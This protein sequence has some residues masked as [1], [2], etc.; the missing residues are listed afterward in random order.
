MLLQ[1]N[2]WLWIKWIRIYCTLHLYY[3]STNVTILLVYN[4]RLRR[5]KMEQRKLTDQANTVADLAKVCAVFLLFSNKNV[6][7]ASVLLIYNRKFYT[8]NRHFYPVWTKFSLFFVSFSAFYDFCNNLNSE[9]PWL[10]NL[11]ILESDLSMSVTISD[12]EHD[13]RSGVRAAASKWWAGQ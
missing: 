2:L 12:S 3:C 5:V 6:L 9:K 11:L 10:A 13:V 7:F 4:F 1:F 8:R